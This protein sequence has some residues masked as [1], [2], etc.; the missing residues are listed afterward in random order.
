[1]SCKMRGGSKGFMTLYSY[2]YC[3]E[4]QNECWKNDA[5]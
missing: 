4:S 5:A 3:T 1:M 2:K